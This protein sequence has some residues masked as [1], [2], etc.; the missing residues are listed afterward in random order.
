M[1]FYSLFPNGGGFG[2]AAAGLDV[3]KNEPVADEMRQ[4]IEIAFDAARRSTYELG[5][6]VPKL[7]EVPLEVHATYSRGEILG[8]LAVSR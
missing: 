7:A 1:L 2:S 6:L 3:L 4:V 5:E 8:A